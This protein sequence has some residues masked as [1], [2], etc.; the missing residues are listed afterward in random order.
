MDAIKRREMGSGLVMPHFSPSS[1]GIPL[2]DPA[3]GAVV[4]AEEITDL[5]E[6]V[7]V[8]DVGFAYGGLSYS[9]STV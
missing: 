1:P 8:L 9:S 4:K 2:H 3:D 6:R 5:R 7:A